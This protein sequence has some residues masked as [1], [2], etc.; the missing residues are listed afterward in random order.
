[1]VTTN[2]SFDVNVFIHY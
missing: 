2:K 1:M